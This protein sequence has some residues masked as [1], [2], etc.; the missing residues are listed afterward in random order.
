[1]NSSSDEESPQTGKAP[2]TSSDSPQESNNTKEWKEWNEQRNG[3]SRRTVKL[4]VGA[5][6]G[7]AA[8]VA[9]FFVKDRLETIENWVSPTLVEATGTVSRAGQPLTK[10]VV[11]TYYLDGSQM[12]ALGAIEPDGTFRLMTN[13]VPGAYSGNHRVVILA[14]SSGMPPKSEVPEQY[15]NA[16]RSPLRIT[17]LRSG[18]NQF[19]LEIVEEAS[20]KDSDPPPAE[21]RQKP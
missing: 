11:Q 18:P 8:V 4:V 15:S 14:M 10:G 12:G 19:P 16:D 20:S 9:V 13:G 6:I 7:I 17:V 21:P 3:G 2:E 5:G 1:M